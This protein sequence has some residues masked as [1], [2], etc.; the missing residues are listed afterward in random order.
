MLVTP[1]ITGLS[2]ISQGANYSFDERVRMDSYYV[3]NLS[4]RLDLIILARTIKVVLMQDGGLPAEVSSYLEQE[5][6]NSA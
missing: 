2:Q 1:G 5:K 6:P 4:I 3:R